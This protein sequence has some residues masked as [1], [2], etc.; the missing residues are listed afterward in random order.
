[1]LPP[2]C[3]YVHAE[4]RVYHVAESEVLYNDDVFSLC[5]G[6]KSPP[7]APP[8]PGAPPDAPPP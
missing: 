5:F 2:G 1:M 8:P 3:V 6:Y 4:N 7:T